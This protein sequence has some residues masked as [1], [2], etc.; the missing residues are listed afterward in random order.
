VQALQD[1]VAQDRALLSENNLLK[2]QVTVLTQKLNDMTNIVREALVLPPPPPV[3]IP[4]PALVPRQA[5]Q[6]QS[7]Q[8]P[9]SV[10]EKLSFDLPKEAY[11]VNQNGVVIRVFHEFA[12]TDFEPSPEVAQAL[13]AAVRDA[14]S[15]L[16]RG[17]TDS[18][19]P[20]AINRLIA[21][22][23]AVK[24]RAWLVANGVPATKI[25][26]R[27]SSSGLFLADNSTPDGKALNRR[28][29]IDIRHTAAS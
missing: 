23:R 12:R 4:A 10:P 13:R 3:P 16:V 9:K 24:A 17:R 27:F 7:Q 14:D 8:P 22:E 25:T 6:S 1:R 5:P 15:V 29:E 21:I 11:S 20:D 26:T 19:T 28:V 2:A 18:A